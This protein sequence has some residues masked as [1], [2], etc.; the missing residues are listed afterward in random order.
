MK[1]HKY[2]QISS[3]PLVYLEPTAAEAYAIG[4][5]L[6]ITTGAATK[7]GATATPAYLCMGEIAADAGVKIPAIRLNADMELGAILSASGA[8]LAIGNKVTI[9]SDGVKVT[10]TTASGVF[11]ITGFATSAKA[12]GD[13]VYGR[14]AY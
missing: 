12:A 7:V 4:E 14:F 10:A 11:E 3:T 13:E 2:D 8:S 6:V 5:G 9:A 1:L